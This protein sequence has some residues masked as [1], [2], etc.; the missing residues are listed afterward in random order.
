MVLSSILK[1]QLRRLHR[2][3]EPSPSWACRRV[4]AAFIIE[5]RCNNVIAWRRSDK[6]TIIFS[7]SSQFHYSGML[8]GS[9][10]KARQPPKRVFY[11]L[12]SPGNICNQL[13]TRKTRSLVLVVTGNK[14][15][16]KKL[17]TELALLEGSGKTRSLDVPPCLGGSPYFN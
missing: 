8:D 12:S 10:H 15:G 6:E 4:R 1:F 17:S 5:M 9:Q 11:I 7:R 13:G 16:I 14:S 2:S 3:I